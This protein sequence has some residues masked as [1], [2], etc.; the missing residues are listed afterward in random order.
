M[1]RLAKNYKYII[2]DFDGTINNTA[3]GIYATFTAVLKHFGID[4]S[5]KDLNEHIGPPLKYSYTKLVGEQKC[6][7]AI[8]LHR[9]IFVDINAVEQS[10]IYDGAKEVLDSLYKSGKYRLA[11]ASCKFQPHLLRSLDVF[12]LR[13]YFTSVYAQTPERLYKTD[14]LRE[15]V[16]DNGWNPSECLMIGDTMHDVEGANANGIDVVAVTYGFGKREELLKSN[17]VAY[18][19]E[20]KQILELLLRP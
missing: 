4:A 13:G 19:D 3:P 15:L 9:K 18:V 2:F 11:V 10:Y 12:G 14:V 6:D 16:S 5:G 17:I 7:E 20:P 8:A 1:N